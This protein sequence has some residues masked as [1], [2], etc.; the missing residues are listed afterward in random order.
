[1]GSERKRTL[2][3]SDKAR[4]NLR[5]TL[6]EGSEYSKELP[7]ADLRLHHRNSTCSLM[8]PASKR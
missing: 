5:M 4:G 1:M 3:H 6:L 8:L 7:R 2:N